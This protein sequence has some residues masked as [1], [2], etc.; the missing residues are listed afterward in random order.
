MAN[1]SQIERH[2]LPDP[3]AAAGAVADW[4]LERALAVEDRPAFCLAG[5]NTPRVVYSMLA[6]PPFRDRFPWARAQT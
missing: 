2:V 3:T 1:A 4:L 5:G 6:A